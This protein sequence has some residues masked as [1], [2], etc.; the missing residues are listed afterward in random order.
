MANEHL[1][2]ASKVES[3][4]LPNLR[5]LFQEVR[6]KA[7]DGDKEWVSLDKSLSTDREKFTKLT[8]VLKLSL[9]KQ[10]AAIPVV[11]A[12]SGE[13]LPAEKVNVPAHLKGETI[14]K[15]PW[16]A[17]HSMYINQTC[18]SFPIFFHLA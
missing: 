9:E 6:R 1:S 4:T 10:R 16:L 2:L 13:E 3:Q 14:P 17:N 18:L 12:E 5:A 15:D 7:T 8:G 11:D